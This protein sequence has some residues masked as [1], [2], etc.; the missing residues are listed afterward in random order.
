[1]NSFRNT[2]EM[3]KAVMD[4]TGEEIAETHGCTKIR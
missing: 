2:D 3:D 4:R 1:M